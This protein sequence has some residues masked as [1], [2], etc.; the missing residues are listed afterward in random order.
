MKGATAEDFIASK[1]CVGCF[2]P[3]T[4]SSLPAPD[5]PLTV[6]Q[7]AARV[8][9]TEAFAGSRSGS[10]TA[11]AEMPQTLQAAAQPGGGGPAA[12]MAL[13]ERQARELDALRNRN[14]A[15]AQE[16]IRSRHAPPASGD[17]AG[18]SPAA[19]SSPP[20]VA[21]ASAAAVAPSSPADVEA[22]VAAEMRAARAEMDVATLKQQVRGGYD[23][24]LS[25]RGLSD[26]NSAR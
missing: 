16:L 13:M 1:R 5:T 15:L 26:M 3:G 20:A 11:G 21:S 7:A 14:Q 9:A 12:A 2:A 19:S 22:R 24:M 17:P 23:I 4:G 6:S 25:G 10:G 18:T 8:Q